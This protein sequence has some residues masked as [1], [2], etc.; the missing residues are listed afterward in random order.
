MKEYVLTV[1]E[2]GRVEG[3]ANVALIQYEHRVTRI[4]L[5]L[6]AFIA[7]FAQ[8]VLCASVTAI[9]G[10]KRFVCLGGVK[11]DND[12]LI[13]WE[14]SASDTRLSGTADIVVTVLFAQGREACTEYATIRIIPVQRVSEDNLSLGAQ[15]CLAGMC[16][17]RFTA[18][19]GDLTNWG[20]KTDKRLVKMDFFNNREKLRWSGYAQIGPQG[21]SS[22]AYPKKNFS[23][24]LFDDAGM[25]NEAKARFVKEWNAQSAYCLKANWIDPTHGCNVVSAR[26]ARDMMEG[27]PANASA[28]C[29]GLIDGYPSIVWLDDDCT[30]VYTMNIPKKPWMFGMDESDENHIV[31]CAEDQLTE[32]AFRAEATASGWS[33]EVGSA[34]SATI[35]EKFNKMVSFVKDTET[36]AEF[37]NGF[38]SHLDLDACLNYYC[39]TYLLGATDNLGKNMLMTTRDGEVWAPSLYDLDSL[40][41]V[42]W[43]GI[44][45]FASDSPCPAKYQCNNSLLWA[46]IEEFYLLE[47]CERYFELREGPLSLDNI[48]RR[49]D[50]F[51]SGIPQAL[52]EYDARR[53]LGIRQMHRSLN[54]SKTWIAERAVYVDDIF[55][56]KY[57]M[58][59]GAPELALHEEDFVS[60]GNSYLDTAQS[61]FT[62]DYPTAT[63]FARIKPA[64]DG[65]VY[66]SAFSERYPDPGYKGLLCR[67][68]NTKLV[69]QISGDTSSIVCNGEGFELSDVTNASGCVEIAIVKKLENYAVFVNGNRVANIN[70]DVPTTITETLLLGA[71][72]DSNGEPFRM[73]TLEIPVFELWHGYFDKDGITKHF[74]EI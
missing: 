58:V 39:F 55:R 10:N 6:S 31:M 28:P 34:E 63:I 32:G 14:P 44:R 22:L 64:S 43:D 37:R 45:Q 49:W 54:Q 2:T 57:N 68:V 48:N 67:Q 24:T 1:D 19:S 46:K 8:K 15:A 5:D 13:Y 59:T 12:G 11:P 20:N 7:S 21:T 18:I 62:G 51:C 72:W 70:I 17:V 36:E 35:L 4:G 30:G 65:T 40:F 50:D 52:Y 42:Q 23:I 26:I 71:Q 27:Y 9:V 41:G 25:T 66:F 3:T 16:E 29:H 74:K 56:T 73:S 47:L 33:V 61:L 69:I 38:S 60:S 53:W